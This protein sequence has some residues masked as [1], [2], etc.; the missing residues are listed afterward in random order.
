MG[1]CDRPWMQGLCLRSCGQC[2]CP[3]SQP[4]AE[5]VTNGETASP[6]MSE[7]VEQGPA[8]ANSGSEPALP[9]AQEPVT[10]ETEASVDREGPMEVEITDENTDA[11]SDEDSANETDDAIEVAPAPD[12]EDSS[13]EDEMDAPV[14]E[15]VI[16]EAVAPSPADDVTDSDEA[17]APSP[18]VIPTRLPD[19]LTVW[20]TV[21]K[22]EEL[23]ELQQTLENAGFVPLLEDAN[24][25]V[26]FFA[27]TNDAMKV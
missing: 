14:L 11:A 25:E 18:A 6:V 20:D 23:S 26:T 24:L 7:T 12:I 22:T 21:T 4:E 16:E 17:I 8:E 10:Q 15:P 9:E 13:A 3:Q 27:P 2:S 1:K 19:C 5:P